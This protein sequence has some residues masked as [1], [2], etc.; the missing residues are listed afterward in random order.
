M[1]LPF[2][3]RIDT[4]LAF[5]SYD[6]GSST[7]LQYQSEPLSRYGSTDSAWSQASTAATSAMSEPSYSSQGWDGSL[8]REQAAGWSLM[9]PTSS[10]VAPRPRALSSGQYCDAYVRSPPRSMPDGADW[11]RSTGKP[12]GGDFCCLAPSCN[13]TF[14]RNA[15][16]DRHYKHKHTEASKKATF[17]CDYRKCNRGREPFHR[18]DHFRDHLRQ[19][20]KE[21]IEK[22]ST[23]VTGGDGRQPGIPGNGRQSWWRCPKCLT[24]YSKGKMGTVIECRQPDCQQQRKDARPRR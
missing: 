11:R 9:S 1:S 13:A 8:T 17:F 5:P 15:D 10:P 16:L 3:E 24:K 23:V 2:P 20:H 12:T 6:P 7:S 18:L 4:S 19:Y 14:R 21:E 22:R